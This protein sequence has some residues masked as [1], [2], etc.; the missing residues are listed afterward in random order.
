GAIS[1]TI[2]WSTYHTSWLNFFG[3]SVAICIFSFVCWLCFQVAP[4]VV[5]ILGNTGINIITRIMGLL[6][7]SLGIEFIITG[8]QSF[9]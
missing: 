6:L 7:M 9:F 4:C 8:I 3:C 5:K 2:A 1:S